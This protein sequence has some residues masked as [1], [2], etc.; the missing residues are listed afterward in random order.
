MDFSN[1][2][3]FATL[4]R[5]MMT[6]NKAAAEQAQSR[7]VQ[8]RDVPPSDQLMKL[9]KFFMLIKQYQMQM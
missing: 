9:V 6:N 8:V 4:H 1:K 2:S 5:L 3:I 7:A